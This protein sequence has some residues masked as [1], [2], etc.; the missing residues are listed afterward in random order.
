MVAVCSLDVLAEAQREACLP[1]R[2]L[3]DA[4]RRRYATALYRHQEGNLQRVG[5]VEGESLPEILEGIDEETLLCGDISESAAGDLWKSKPIRIA[6]PASSLRRAGY[7]A[8]IGWR[9]YQQGDLQD[10][11]RVEALYIGG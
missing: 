2:P 4:G 10:A 1:V 7:L 11:A 8:E 6:S 9:R 3:L 5:P